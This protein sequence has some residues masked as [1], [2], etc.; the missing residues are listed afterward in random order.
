MN[1]LIV[2]L[3]AVLGVLG[4]LALIL[5]AWTLQALFTKEAEAAALAAVAGLLRHIERQL[6]PLY[7]PRFREETKAGLEKLCRER[8]LAALVEAFSLLLS[9]ASGRLAAG[10]E[11]TE[12]GAPP[13]NRETAEVN[14]RK[15]LA[16]PLRVRILIYLQE[17]P[18]SPGELAPLLEEPLGNTAYHFLVLKNY[19][20]IEETGQRQVRGYTEHFFR[21]T[22]QDLPLGG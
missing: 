7:R 8:P 4:G 18:A 15:S 9:A 5:A 22:S 20:L 14:L 2:V 11:A 10:F 3:L 13:K 17:K 19:G 1:A 16:H 6:P 21:A 12:A